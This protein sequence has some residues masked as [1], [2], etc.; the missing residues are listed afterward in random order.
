MASYV[1]FIEAAGGRVVPMPWNQTEEVTREQMSKLDGVLFPG[2]GG[3]YDDIG[4]L[5][6]EE[7]IAINDNG[8]FFPIWGT[9]L[10]YALMSVWTA[11]QPEKDILEYYGSTYH[12]LPIKFTKQPFETKMFCELG[13]EAYMLEKGNY[14]YNNHGVS[15]DPKT[16]KNDSKLS[17]FWDV[18]SV[19]YD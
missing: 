1:K 6:L 16:F 19:S 4:K 17:Q 8:K 10:G 18:T 9:C 15:I 13:P 14:T 2:G 7:A 5:V 3:Y 12:S 11:E